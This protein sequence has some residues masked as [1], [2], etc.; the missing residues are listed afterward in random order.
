MAA[1][2]DRWQNENNTGISV[3]VRSQKE[4]NPHI[5]YDL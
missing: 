3:S 4:E 1:I 5:F 2:P